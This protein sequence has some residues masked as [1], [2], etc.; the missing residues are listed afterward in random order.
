MCFTS[1]SGKDTFLFKLKENL[2]FIIIISKFTPRE[3]T[4]HLWESATYNYSKIE[5][6]AGNFL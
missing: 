4:D 3:D 1:P 2:Y 5:M 6:Q